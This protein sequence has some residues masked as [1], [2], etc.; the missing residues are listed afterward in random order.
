MVSTFGWRMTVLAWLCEHDWSVLPY[1][2]LQEG[3]FCQ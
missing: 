3:W 1:L 2:T